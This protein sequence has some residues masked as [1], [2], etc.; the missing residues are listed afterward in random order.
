MNITKCYNETFRFTTCFLT[1]CNEKE[2]C[3]YASKVFNLNYQ[4]ANATDGD[5]FTIKEKPEVFVIALYTNSLEILAH[6]SL[7]VVTHC[8]NYRGL[9]LTLQSQETYC[10]LLEWLVSNGLKAINKKLKRKH[11]KTQRRLHSKDR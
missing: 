11:A 1:D 7:H 9:E 3:E 8:L 10:Y 4:P 6:E 2:A 5:I